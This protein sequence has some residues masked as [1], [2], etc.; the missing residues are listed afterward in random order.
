MKKSS[1]QYTLT[2]VALI[3]IGWL[4]FDSLTAQAATLWT[5]QAGIYQK[6]LSN[7]A[8][9]RTRY[10]IIAPA[11]IAAT[12]E[13]CL[14]SAKFKCDADWGV[15]FNLD[16]AVAGQCNRLSVKKTDLSDAAIYS[17]M[18]VVNGVAVCP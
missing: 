2:I 16:E 18:K 4:A 5:P 8:T 3:F 17:G 14:K 6:Q 15:V 7:A 11:P 10:V 9:P 13:Q 12:A 1:I